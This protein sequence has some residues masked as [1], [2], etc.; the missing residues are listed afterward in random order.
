MDNKRGARQILV[1]T[2]R[3]EKGLAIRRKASP[4]R[5][6]HVTQRPPS[7]SFKKP[8]RGHTTLP[9]RSPEQVVK[10]ILPAIA[11]SVDALHGLRLHGY[12]SP[13]GRESRPTTVAM[14]CEDRLRAQRGCVEYGHRASLF[15]GASA[16]AAV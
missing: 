6:G 14:Q 2:D 12:S 11:D 1:G 3:R 15:A 5:S 9:N 4:P 13:V 10:Q 7:V 16:P 8:H